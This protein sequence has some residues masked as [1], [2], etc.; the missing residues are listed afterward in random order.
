M[1]ATAGCHAEIMQQRVAAP[2]FSAAVAI[3]PL[4]DGRFGAELG[5]LWTVGPKAHGGLLVVLLDR[6]STRLNS[7][8]RP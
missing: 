6:K 7:S 8:H 1:I 5:D 4:G 2:P 3:E